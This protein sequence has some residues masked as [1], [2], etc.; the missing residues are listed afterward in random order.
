MNINQAGAPDISGFLACAKKLMTKGKYVFVDRRKNFTG[1]IR[2][3]I[4]YR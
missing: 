4:N 2:V 1:S 3:R